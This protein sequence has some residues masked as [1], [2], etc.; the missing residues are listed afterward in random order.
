[1]YRVVS[2]WRLVFLV[3]VM[4][5]MVDGNDGDGVDGRVLVQLAMLSLTT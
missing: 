3:A 2:F 4:I 5:V 1:M